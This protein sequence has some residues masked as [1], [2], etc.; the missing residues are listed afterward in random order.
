[1]VAPD[2]RRFMAYLGFFAAYCGGTAIR[3]LVISDEW[4]AALAVITP[5]WIVGQVF[6]A[7]CMVCIGYIYSGR[8]GTPPP[9]PRRGAPRRR[10]W[11][12]MTY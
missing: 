9:Q 1:M 2:T 3:L 4:R 6:A 11:P 7:A 10:R 5:E 12:T 8:P